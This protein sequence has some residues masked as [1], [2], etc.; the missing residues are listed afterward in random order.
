MGVAP[1]WTMTAQAAEYRETL[2]IEKQIKDNP[3]LRDAWVK[4]QLQMELI[5][6][7]TPDS[8]DTASAAASETPA[9]LQLSR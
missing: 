9:R 4:R 7:E 1:K 2:A 5:E 8:E 3:A 6:R